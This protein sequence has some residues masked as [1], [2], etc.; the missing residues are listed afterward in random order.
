[1]GIKKLSKNKYHARYFAGYGSNG[2]RVYPSKT[3]KTRKDANTWLTAKLREKHLGEYAEASTLSLSQYIDQ[4][5]A[6]KKTNLREN[7]FYVYGGYI[8]QYIRPELGRLKLIAIKPST[9]EQ[10]QARLLARVSGRTVSGARV[11]LG[12]IFRHAVRIHLLTYNPVRDAEAPKWKRKKKQAFT[13]EEA[14]L[15]MDHCKGRMDGL[16]LAFMLNTGLRP[17][18]VMGLRWPDLSL[19]GARG[20][21]SVREVCLRLPG[22]GWRL[23]T[24]KS[25]SSVRVIG[26]PAWLALELRDARKRQLEDQMRAGR[27]RPSF[28]LVFPSKFGTPITLARLRI[29]F[30]AILTAA[31]LPHMRL[32][33]LRHSFVTLSLAAGVDP[34]TVSDEAGHASTAFT[35]DH[36]GHVLK[37]MRDGA[38]DKREELFAAH[39]MKSK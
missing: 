18:E 24:P 20:V 25:D 30:E 17:E 32:Y 15:F 16:C 10:W 8:E 5:L 1:M 9:I 11:L 29:A 37:I 6:I 2:K 27:K 31:E 39:K 26:F 12:G 36:Y 34:K 19:E 33:D 21:C 38:V 35:L 14:N 28:D 7:T 3:F 13:P 22:G 23:D 4:W